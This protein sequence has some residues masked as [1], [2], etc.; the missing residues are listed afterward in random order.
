MTDAEN[1]SEERVEAAFRAGRLARISASSNLKTAARYEMSEGEKLFMQ[2]AL[3]AD[4][5]YAAS[6]YADGVREGLRMARDEL[7]K[8]GFGIKQVR[9]IF[10]LIDARIKEWK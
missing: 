6:R 2:A 4:A 8:H 1:V 7:A 5:P 10:D 9:D 3:L